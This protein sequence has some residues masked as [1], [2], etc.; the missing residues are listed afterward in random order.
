MLDDDYLYPDG[1]GSDLWAEAG[2][3]AAVLKPYSESWQ[4]ASGAAISVG[5]VC[6]SMSCCMIECCAER[7]RGL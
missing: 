6:A 3:Q 2:T 1:L 4:L 7:T 5:P